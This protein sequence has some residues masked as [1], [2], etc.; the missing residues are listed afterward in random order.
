[1]AALP[2]AQWLAAAD[3]FG[4]GWRTNVMTQLALESLTSVVTNASRSPWEATRLQI[5]W[6]RVSTHS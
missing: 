1:V 6:E 2:T 3:G 5:V 4:A